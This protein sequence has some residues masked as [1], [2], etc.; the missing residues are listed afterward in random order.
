MN[1]DYSKRDYLLPEGCKDLVDVLR[2]EARNRSK[3][4][5]Q[6]LRTN[7]EIRQAFRRHVPEI[8]AGTVEIVS[9]ARDV[10]HHC[11]LAV[12]S[13]DLKLSA[14]AACA[15]MRGDRLKTISAELGGELPHV[16]LWD[17]SPEAF[18]R[19]AIGS[20]NEVAFD[21]DARQAVVTIHA[22]LHDRKGPSLQ[23]LAGLV[24]EITGWKIRFAKI[25]S[26]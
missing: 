8:A 5:R 23:E 3:E 15:G 20:F 10:G 17:S 25:E 22:L 18:I 24:S 1:H 6:V 26:D 21:C 16:V 13:H 4:F 19:N 11:L 9:L 12:R 7:E 14:V 2:L